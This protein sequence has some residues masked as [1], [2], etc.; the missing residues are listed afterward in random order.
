MFEKIK[1]GR[2]GAMAEIF[3]VKYV[4][5]QCSYLLGEVNR[6]FDPTKH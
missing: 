3:H 1:T 2:R 4:E 6:K 5:I